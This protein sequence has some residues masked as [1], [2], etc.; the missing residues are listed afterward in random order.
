MGLSPLDRYAFDCRGWLRFDDVV[1]GGTVAALRRAIADQRLAP[2]GDAK[3]P[4]YTSA[5]T[6]GVWD[7]VLPYGALPKNSASARRR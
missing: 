7:T 2:P 5:S 1:D 3:T 6:A 4:N